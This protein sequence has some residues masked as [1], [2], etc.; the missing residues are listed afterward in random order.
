MSAASTIALIAHVSTI[1][2]NSSGSV[3]SVVCV[4]RLYSVIGFSAMTVFRARATV[5]LCLLARTR[6][7]R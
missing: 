2:A 5:T 4:G 3:V 7:G 1:A 6:G